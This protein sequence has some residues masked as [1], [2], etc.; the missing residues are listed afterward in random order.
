MEDLKPC[1]CGRKPA[2]WKHSSD[3]HS[4]YC[5]ECSVCL[6]RT[7]LMTTK[8]AAAIKAWNRRAGK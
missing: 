5:I 7:E 6:V 2:I 3:G 8:A 4:T 1:K